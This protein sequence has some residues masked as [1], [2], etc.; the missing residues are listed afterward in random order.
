[1][2]CAFHRSPPRNKP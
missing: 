1:M 2:P